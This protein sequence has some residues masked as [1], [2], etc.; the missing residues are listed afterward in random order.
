MNRRDFFR[1]TTGAAAGLAMAPLVAFIPLELEEKYLPPHGQSKP[2]WLSSTREAAQR[3]S[4][5][6][7]ASAMSAMSFGAQQT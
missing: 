6:L 4:A 5:M 2:L 1:K 3:M 7:A